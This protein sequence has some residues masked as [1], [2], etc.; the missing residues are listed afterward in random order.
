MGV[1]EGCRNIQV[2][3]GCRND[4]VMENCPIT[5]PTVHFYTIGGVFGE[6]KGGC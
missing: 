5:I 2:M 1:D 6:T 4:A 3:D